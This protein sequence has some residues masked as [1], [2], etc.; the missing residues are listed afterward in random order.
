MLVL[1]NL[2]VVAWFLCLFG[3]TCA[4]LSDNITPHRPVLV[5]TAVLLGAVILWLSVLT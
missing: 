2:F 5:F 4:A 1:L 3:V